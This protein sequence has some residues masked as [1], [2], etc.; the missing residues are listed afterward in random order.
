LIDFSCTI[1]SELKLRKGHLRYFFRFA[2][3]EFLP[4][5]T[6]NK[7]KHGF[8]LPFGVWLK[9]HKPLRELAYD[10]LE[11]LKTRYYFNP[12]FIDKARK[13]HESAH[14]GYYGELIWVMMMLELWIST[15][16]HSGKI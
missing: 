13:M 16:Q 8:G 3:Q 15:H 11:K 9:D 4:Q 7:S 5:A 12:A 2:M 14:A 1:P 6:L 10:S